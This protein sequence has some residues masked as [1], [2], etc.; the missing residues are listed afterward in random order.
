MKNYT[1]LIATIAFTVLGY[2][3]VKAQS[4]V[5]FFHLGDYVQQSTDVSPVYIP[6]NSFSFGLPSIGLAVGNG[7]A[8][9]DLLT[10]VTGTEKLEYNYKN[11]YN[12][13]DSDYNQLNQKVTLNILNLA[14]KRKHGSISFFVNAKQ[15]MGWHMSKNGIVNLLANGINDEVL[16]NDKINTT[17]YAE[18]GVGFTQ[19]FLN[20]KL[21]V[22]VRVKYIIGLANGSTEEDGF[23]K[24]NVNDDL[25]WTINTQNAIAR[26]S[27]YRDGED[28]EF[29]TA[30]TGFGFDIGASYEIIPNLVVEAAVNDI[31]SITWKEK[32]TEYYLEDVTNLVVDGVDLDTD[33]DIIEELGDKLADDV[34]HGEREGE[35][36][37]TSLATNTYI[38]ASYKLGGIHQFRATMFNDLKNK[39]NSATIALGYNVA[40]DRTTYGV[41]GIKNAQGDI[42]FGL[43]LATKLGPLQIFLATDNI[44]KVLGAVQDIKQVNLRFGL[45]FVFGYNKWL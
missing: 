3:S 41:V 18:G 19:Q 13:L 42:D 9:S 22:G 7:F 25:T 12:T 35:S 6:K 26:V 16:F 44:N 15:N 29:S 20:D 8:S 34:G 23:A 2:N 17:V 31:G 37:K 11:V 30:N 5:S 4:E 1:K 32:V 14:F 45:N 33:G 40:L 39:D 10:P 28:Y 27:G 36:Y 24:I 38:S 21:A 43:N